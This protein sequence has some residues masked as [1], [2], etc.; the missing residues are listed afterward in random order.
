MSLNFSRNKKK[1]EKALSQAKED[2]DHLNEKLTNLQQGRQSDGKLVTCW[3]WT[4]QYPCYGG[5]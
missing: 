1:L 5:I 4:E 2:I 3:M